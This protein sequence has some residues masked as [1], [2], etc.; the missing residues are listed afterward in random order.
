MRTHYC[1]QVGT[2]ALG[3]IVT[4]CGWVDRRR[5]H[6]GVIFLDMR[7]R[8]GIVQVVADPER[9]PVAGDLRSEF[10]L[11]VTGEVTQ[12]P[13]ESLNPKLKTGNIEIKVRELTVLNPSKTPP[14][15]IADESEVDEKLR[16]KYRYLDLRR[17][18]LRENIALRHRIVKVIRRYLEDVLDFL[19]IETP[20]LTKS[21]PEGARDYLVPSRVNPGE[22][23]ALP[24]SPQLFKQ[25]LM[26]AGFDRYYQIARCF[27][28]ED[29]R[30]DRQPEFTQLDMELSF[31][32]QEQVIKLNEGLVRKIFQEVKG[33]DVPFE[34]PRLT[35][36]EAMDR[37]GSDKPDTRF[38]ME[39]I[40][41]SQVFTG[42]GFKVFA[43]VLQAGGVV[44]ALAVLGGD[45]RISNVRIKPGGDLFNLVAQF[46]A[47]GLAFIRVRGT[48]GNLQ[49]DT[50]GALKD[51]LTDDQMAQL[52]EITAAKPGDLLLFGAGPCDV[53]NEYLGRL[54]LHLGA[55]LGLIDPN[56]N[57]LLWVTDFPMFEL[58][59][60]EGRLVALHHP[61][62]APNPADLDKL[63]TPEK[64]GSL[65]PQDKVKAL[66][67][68]ALAYDLVWNGVEL[69]GGSIR[70]HQRE[71]QEKV[72]TAIG[73]TTELARQQFGFLLEAF[74]YGAPPHGGIAFGLDRMVMLFA[75]ADSIR[76]VI[77]FPK[78][79]KAQDLMCDAP[80]T[81][82]PRQLK[83]LYVRSTHDLKP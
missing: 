11:Q 58:N 20:V 9:F 41:A 48:V 33:L 5:D 10:V 79:Q 28:D 71:V 3:E 68:R 55:E 2:A 69:G 63:P 81:V 8:S 16:L 15:A 23:Y 35:Y 59:P 60:E 46:G 18:Q 82:S 19:E 53:V 83:E 43:S 13:E 44:K 52:I 47:K 65:T 36:R 40:D 45:E 78:T 61:F 74:E 80:S 54:R 51:S 50:I 1:A 21:T 29:L 72:F 38:G 64:A 66:E 56:Q 12:R 17:A 14:F 75:Q 31:V 49:L 24:Q 57:N 34:F 32:D 6:G 25:I 4:V 67:A 73:F 76:E 22:W 26:V 42:T 37:Y 7:D 70:I 30:A 62:T 77:A 39:L 27:R